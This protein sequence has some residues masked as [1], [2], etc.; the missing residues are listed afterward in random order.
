MNK[1]L[2]SLQSLKLPDW[3][4]RITYHKLHKYHKLFA[5]IPGL[6]PGEKHFDCFEWRNI[7]GCRI[8]S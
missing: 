5:K 3:S 7:H 8:A 1:I 4:E 6:A 2:T